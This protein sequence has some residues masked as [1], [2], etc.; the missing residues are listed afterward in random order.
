MSAERFVYEGYEIDATRHR[1][2]CRYALGSRRFNE[3]VEL[4]PPARADERDAWTA[5]W[6]SPAVDAAARILF[7]LAG[8]SYYKTA[9]PPLIDLG[10]M[11]TTESER[12]FLRTFYVEGLGEFAHRNGLDLSVID[13]V[14]PSLTARRPAPAALRGG[15]P[16]VPFGAG[17]DSVVT[18]EH[19][20]RCE[21]RA[22]LFVVSRAGDRYAAIEDA[23]SM[24]GLPIVRAARQVDP[25]VLRSAELGFLN[26]HVPVT[27]ILSA[28]AVVAAV[29]GGHG[30]VVMSN[31][32]SASAPSVVTDGR[33][34]N[35]QWSKSADFEAR[36]RSLV[37]S[38]LAPAPAY[39]SYL[40][41]RSELWVA[42]E[43]AHLDRYHHVVRSCNRAFAIDPHRRLD[44][45]CGTCD[46]CCFV[47]LVLSPYLDAAALSSIFDGRE[48]LGNQALLANFR[49]LV[50]TGDAHRPFECVGDEE[51]C[52]AAVVLAAAR[53]DRRGTAQLQ[54][55]A[56]EVCAATPR[57]ADPRWQEGELSRLLSRDGADFVP[58]R[59]RAQDASARNAL[60]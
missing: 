10:S 57:W 34:I 28:I 41:A 32:H 45:W 46:K 26:G 36:F 21:P 31:E 13:V 24:T 7:L 38:S 51:E 5:A 20:A 14:G 17:I 40:R 56:A 11:P 60:A 22:S 6:A 39:F 43:L 2:V 18:A 15:Y 58:A 12:S 52:R 47:D 44:R 49:A 35:H 16:L 19:I 55:L 1:I 4:A 33:S 27:G 30:E 23:A 3:I 37:E 25:A 29:L 8:V 50:G 54:M 42:R 53:E 59:Y 9:A 48:P